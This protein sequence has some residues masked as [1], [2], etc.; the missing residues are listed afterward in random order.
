MIPFFGGVPLTAAIARPA[1]R[2]RQPPA[3]SGLVLLA[4]MPACA[5]MSTSPCPPLAVLIVT[6]WRMNDFTIYKISFQALQIAHNK[7]T[8]T[9]VS[10]VVFT[11][12][13]ILIGA[14]LLC[15]AHNPPFKARWLEKVDMTRMAAPT[16]PWPCGTE[17]VVSYVTGPLIFN[18]GQS[19]YFERQGL[20]YPAALHEGVSLIDISGAE[21][22]R[23]DKMLKEGVDIMCACPGAP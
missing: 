13:A 9:I 19:G 17:A 12:A 11:S 23:T 14:S 1:W 8:A 20:R 16:R 3:S 10:T 18:T 2:W 6:A 22:W 5:P 4:A 15:A 7:F 21:A